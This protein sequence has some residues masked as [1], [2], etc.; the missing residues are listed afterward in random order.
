MASAIRLEL[1]GGEG[2]CGSSR[3]RRERGSGRCWRLNE[4]VVGG[5]RGGATVGRGGSRHLP[6]PLRSTIRGEGGG[7]RD[8][9]W[10]EISSSPS[11]SVSVA[12]ESV[13][14]S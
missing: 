11:S 5:E 14:S 13:A 8:E 9:H 7:A 6:L 12:D 4:W 2:R 1:V 3:D 10:L